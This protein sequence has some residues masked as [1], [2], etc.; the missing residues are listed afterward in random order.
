M[1]I[2]NETFESF[3][4]Q[5][6]KIDEAIN[7]LCDHNYKIIDPKNELISKRKTSK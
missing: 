2:Y 1:P 7:L 3:R 6:R 4:Q 5:A